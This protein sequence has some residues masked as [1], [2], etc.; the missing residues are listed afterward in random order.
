V[1]YIELKCEKPTE[2]ER[3][4]ILIADLADLGFES[5]SEEEHHLLAYIPDK[6]YSDALL[7][8]NKYLQEQHKSKLL[9]IN[10]IKEQNWNA[11]WESNYEPVIIKKQC[12]IRAPF[13]P[14]NSE[15][16]FD[17]VIQPKMSF[18]TAHHET[19]SLII[20]ILLDEEIKG[21]KVLDM[22]CGTGV[23]AILSS[24]KGARNILAVDNDE[25][26]YNNSLEN[27]ALNKIDNLEVKLG[28]TGVFTD[29]IFDLILANINKNV[30]LA[31]IATYSKVLVPGGIII[32][33]GFYTHDLEDIKSEAE[34]NGLRY[35]FHKEKN[36][37][38]AAVFK[39]KS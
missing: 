16:E 22:G 25:W 4:E 29:E 33:S 2:Q 26:A 31:D 12:R 15:I 1:N 27:I 21:M 19:T 30:L 23:L 10:F 20:E 28:D 24:F 17:L 11:V 37:W 13:H 5:F 39:S 6:E 14:T 35:Q 9:S 3:L 34:K 36:K 7:A 18:G 32:F 8:A 38:V